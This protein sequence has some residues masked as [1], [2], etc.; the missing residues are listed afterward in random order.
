MNELQPTLQD[1]SPWFDSLALHLDVAEELSPK[2]GIECKFLKRRSP[3]R[4]PLWHDFLGFL[5][6]RGLCLYE[7]REALLEFPGYSPTDTDIC[8]FPLKQLADQLEMLYQS[9]FVRTIYHIKL[10]YDEKSGWE[11]KAYL[12]VN[13]IWKGIGGDYEKGRGRWGIIM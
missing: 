9:F 1:I 10:V 4:E 12:G 11:A 5:V 7:K 3:D 8:P 6:E 13:H 2:I